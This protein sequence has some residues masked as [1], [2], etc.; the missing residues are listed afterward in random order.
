M[1]PIPLVQKELLNFWCPTAKNLKATR[2]NTLPSFVIALADNTI[3]GSLKAIRIPFD[4]SVYGEVFELWLGG[5]HTRMR[6]YNLFNLTFANNIV[7][8]C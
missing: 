5:K 4:K 1:I 3:F 7:I 8:F 6:Y 2:Y